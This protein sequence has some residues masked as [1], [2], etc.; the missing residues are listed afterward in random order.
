MIEVSR[1]GLTVG[2]LDSTKREVDNCG[3][4]LLDKVVLCEPFD[5]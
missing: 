3:I 4:S 2:K 5:V 1:I